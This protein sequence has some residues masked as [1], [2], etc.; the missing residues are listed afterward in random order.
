MCGRW[1]ARAL[2]A[3]FA[4][5]AVAGRAG[6]ADVEVIK[7]GAVKSAIDL[8][9]LRCSGEAG[10][11]FQRT[12]ENDL[13]LSGWFTIARGGA[14]VAADGTC[15]GGGGALRLDCQVRHASSGR[16][17]VR[18][19]DQGAAD[20]ARRMAH[21]LADEIVRAVTGK[22]GIASTRIV[23]VGRRAGRKDIYMCDAD[24]GNL[25][26]ITRDGVVCLAPSWSPTGEFIV[27]TAFLKGFPDVY[28]ID[29]N[30]FRRTRVAGYPGLNAGADVSPDGRRIVLTLSK[31]G[32]PDLYVLGLGG[33]QAA[34]VTRTRFAAEASP[35]WSPDGRSIVFVSDNSGSPQLYVTGAGGGGYQRIT[36]RGTENVAPD[37]GPDGRIAYSSR[38]GGKYRVCVIDQS[39]GGDTEIAADHADYEDPS[40]APDGRHIVCSRTENYRSALVMLDTLG[41]S[42]IQLLAVEGDWYSPAWSP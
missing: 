31:D 20:D 24:G 37:W 9:G 1:L 15:A 25:R 2:A 13:R 27:Y 23:T 42:P 7:A 34:R 35:S 21:A 19:S 16:V 29:M 18:R 26:Q 3:A 12:L 32:N 8:S 11:V 17:Y 22:R 4:A 30:G 40:W 10:S 38:R 39:G 33:G 36:L 14:A 6:A 28:R 5:G 41:D